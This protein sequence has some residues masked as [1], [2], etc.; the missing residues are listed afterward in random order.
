MYF[1]RR[2]FSMRLEVIGCVQEDLPALIPKIE[3]ILTDDASI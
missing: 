3:H 1:G 2:G